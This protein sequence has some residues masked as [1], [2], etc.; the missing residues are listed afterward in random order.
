MCLPNMSLAT[1]RLAVDDRKKRCSL[2]D[3]GFSSRVI[4]GDDDKY[5]K[6]QE[7]VIRKGDCNK[8]I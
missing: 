6:W 4:S 3:K 7:F 8:E 1:K 2:K 5:I